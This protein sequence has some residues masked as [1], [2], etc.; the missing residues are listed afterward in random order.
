ML[1][2]DEQQLRALCERDERAYVERVREQL[3]PKFPDL[4]ADDTLSGRLLRALH[5]AQSWGLD[6]DALLLAFL[7]AEAVAPN[8]Y[9]RPATTAWLTRP[10]HTFGRRL[11]EYV[12]VLRWSADLQAA[13]ART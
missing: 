7:S 8:F 3:L 11:A 10:G 2:F 4:L 5:V 13:Q 6:D 9:L 12:S 1:E